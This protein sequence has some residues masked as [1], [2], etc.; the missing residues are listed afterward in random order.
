MIVVISWTISSK[1]IL[2]R[3]NFTVVALNIVCINIESI[4]PFLIYICCN[5]CIFCKSV[6]CKCWTCDIC[7]L[8][9][10]YFIVISILKCCVFCDEVITSYNEYTTPETSVTFCIWILI[11]CKYFIIKTCNWVYWIIVSTNTIIP[12]DSMVITLKCYIWSCHNCLLEYVCIKI[13][14][15]SACFSL[16]SVLH[17]K[18]CVWSFI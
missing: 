15:N 16:R 6:Y 7:L 5:I 4:W 11:S 1:C 2:W 18:N 9:F 17:I 12:W 13:N 8:C 3:K 10:C 14:C